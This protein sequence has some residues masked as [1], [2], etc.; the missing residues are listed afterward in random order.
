[1]LFLD[2]CL[3]LFLG[4]VYCY[5]AATCQTGD[6]VRNISAN[7]E[8]NPNTNRNP[9]LNPNP[10][11]NIYTPPLCLTDCSVVAIATPLFLHLSSALD[12]QL[13]STQQRT[14]D[15]GV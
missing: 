1:M 10:N 3:P 15:A 6:R 5:A 11:S 7:A 12:L 13:N 4:R 9:N 8:N 14:T 2:N